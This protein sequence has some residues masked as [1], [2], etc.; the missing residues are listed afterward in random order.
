[1]FRMQPIVEEY[2]KFEINHMKGMNAGMG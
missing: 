1:M 2:I